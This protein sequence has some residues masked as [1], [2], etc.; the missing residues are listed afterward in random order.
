MNASEILAVLAALGAGVS[1]VWTKLESRRKEMEANLLEK[2]KSCEKERELLVSRVA[3]IEASMDTDVPSWRR[4]QDGVIIW[5]NKEFIRMFGAP[6]G[7]KAADV[8]GKTFDQLT[9]FSPNLLKDLHDM[10]RHALATGY[11]S[12]S[13][14]EVSKGIK[15]TIIKA[16]VSGSST[17]PE[18]VVYIGYAVPELNM[19]EDSTS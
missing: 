7:Y 12:K 11:S 9:Q 3:A 2:F 8:R 13:G 6:H 4:N 14:V 5:V 15:A 1:W 16:A 17:S 18:D 10:D 19:L